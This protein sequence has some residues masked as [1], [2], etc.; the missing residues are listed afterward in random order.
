MG[1]PKFPLPEGIT[2]SIQDIASN[3]LKTATDIVN[4]ASLAANQTVEVATGVASNAAE[5]VTTTVGN[6]ASNVTAAIDSQI[7]AKED[8]VAEKL[9]ATEGLRRTR[10]ESLEADNARRALNA[11]SDSPIPTTEDN[12]L[13]VKD[14]FPIP[15]EQD[16][17]WIDAEFDLRPSGIIA[18]N[19]GIFIKSDAVVFTLPFTDTDNANTS[20]ILNF[21]PWS[22]LNLKVSP[23][24]TETTKLFQSISHVLIGLLKHAKIL[25]LLSQ[26]P[27][28]ATMCKP[29]MRSTQTPTR[30]LQL[31]LPRFSLM[32]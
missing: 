15:K 32:K 12:I 7:K 4:N 11:L 23:L 2:S 31:E 26:S 28:Q 17:L 14:C 19:K 13:K 5:A 30:R 10:I 3:A 9:L 1:F 24:K 21:V 8:A 18:T 27:I 22:F 16:I 6:V 29:P 25:P 20:S